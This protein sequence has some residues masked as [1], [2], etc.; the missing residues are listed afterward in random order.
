MPDDD[1]WLLRAQSR[2]SARRAPR[3]SPHPPP[4]PSV[5]RPRPAARRP[6]AM[7]LQLARKGGQ[8]ETGVIGAVASRFAQRTKS[9]LAATRH[10]P[11][12]VGH[13]PRATT[14]IHGSREWLRSF[15]YSRW[16]STGSS[17]W[18]SWRCPVL[19]LSRKV[20]REVGSPSSTSAS[21]RWTPIA[22]CHSAR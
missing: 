18:F 15:A 8:G 17:P 14:P 7:D 16:R 4:V 22:F 2:P 10:D 1:L 6:G 12:K 20:A 11:R 13:H 19:M 3:G 21:C 5:A 9:K